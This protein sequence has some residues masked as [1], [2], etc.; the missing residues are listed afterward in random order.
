MA[1]TKGLRIYSIFWPLGLVAYWLGVLAWVHFFGFDGWTAVSLAA[2]GL[3]VALWLLSTV[4]LLVAIDKARK[5]KPY[6]PLPG[7]GKFPFR[8]RLEPLFWLIAPV[9]FGAG[10]FIGH[11]YW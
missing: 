3:V 9:G 2:L 8:E 6:E 5:G 11:Q 10:L 4:D 1:M 7:P